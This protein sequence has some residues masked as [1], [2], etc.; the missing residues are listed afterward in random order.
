M[1]MLAAEAKAATDSRTMASV[2]TG[3]EPAA[4][5]DIAGGLSRWPLQ[6]KNLSMRRQ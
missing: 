5:T 6:K 4:G 3:R 1:R 2:D